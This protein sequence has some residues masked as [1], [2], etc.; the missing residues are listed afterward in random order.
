MDLLLAITVGALSALLFAIAA[1]SLS[2]LSVG[3]RAVG[4]ASE[5]VIRGLRAATATIAPGSR[6]RQQPTTSVRDNERER[7]PS[8]SVERL[9]DRRQSATELR[10]T[11]A[12]GPAPGSTGWDSHAERR[13]C[14]ACRQVNL[15]PARFCRSC[16]THLRA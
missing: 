1:Q 4:S 14:P 6:N 2:V 8:P 5:A 11:V 13:P 9:G 16:G 12:A 7:A 10:L 15:A 3:A